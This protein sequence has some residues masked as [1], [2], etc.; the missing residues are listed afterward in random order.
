M[1]S[2][3]GAA[4]APGVN[5]RAVR[6][7]DLSR[8]TVEIAGIR[9]ELDSLAQG[10]NLRRRAGGRDEITAERLDYTARWLMEE[11]QVRAETE[12]FQQTLQV[13]QQRRERARVYMPT[14]Q[15]GAINLGTVDRYV[16]EFS[17]TFTP[18][19]RTG[20]T[21]EERR[22]LS[23]LTEILEGLFQNHVRRRFS[24]AAYTMTIPFTM[25]EYQPPPLEPP[26]FIDRIGETV[27]HEPF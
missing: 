25:P 9:R 7:L 1:I 12:V 14:Q 19:D 15:Y 8:F 18:D 13:E 23:T 6:E 20:I 26:S 11:V 5:Q 24:L 17:H 27:C 4:A 10:V 16:F 22:I 2:N 3:Y 21:G